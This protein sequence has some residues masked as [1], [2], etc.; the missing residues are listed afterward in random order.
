VPDRLFTPTE[1]SAAL[2]TVR[3]L[4]ELLVERRAALLVAQARLAELLATVA[5]NGG[6][7]EPRVARELAAAAQDAERE[8]GAVIAELTDAGVIVRDLDAG[9]VDF[10]SL[11]D[12]EPVFL[13]WQLGEDD[14]AW[15]HGPEDGFGGRKPL[16]YG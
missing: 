9:L 2:P 5:G 7:I 15:W 14:V 8:L 6:G 12:G 3:P 11:R 1:A 13:C 4:V 16:D 10:P